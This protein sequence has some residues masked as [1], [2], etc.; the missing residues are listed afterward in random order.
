MQKK[1][2]NPLQVA[3]H[4]TIYTTEEAL[5]VCDADTYT[6]VIMYTEKCRPVSNTNKVFVTKD[7]A[8][9]TSSRIASVLSD[10]LGRDSRSTFNTVRHAAISIVSTHTQS[11]ITCREQIIQA[12]NALILKLHYYSRES[13]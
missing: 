9:L 3:D 4:K 8:P 10:S 12:V 1:N 11:E 6:A 7:G 2:T 5:V 13:I